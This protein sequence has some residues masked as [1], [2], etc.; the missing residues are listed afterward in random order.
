[1]R[2]RLIYLVSLSVAANSFAYSQPII[3][4]HGGQDSEL[5]P[6]QWQVTPEA[7]GV[8]NRVVE[9]YRHYK[10]QYL[11]IVGHDENASTAELSYERAK[12][13]AEAARRA[14]IDLGLPADRLATKSCSFDEPYELKAGPEP[15]NRRVN[16]AGA[17]SLQELLEIDR[18]TCPATRAPAKQS[19]KV[20]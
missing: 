15:L 14:L 10:V 9:E 17:S 2:R 19:P 5:N 18:T 20:R 8:L 13:R 12:L 11:L 16:F 3:F 1:M 4:F 7:N 6:R